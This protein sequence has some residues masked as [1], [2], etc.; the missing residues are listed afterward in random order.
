MFKQGEN[1]RSPFGKSLPNLCEY[2]GMLPNHSQPRSEA[3]GFI[4]A[5]GLY[6]LDLRVFA[7]R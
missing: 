2:R 4:C 6:L 7:G 3:R 1:G 5:G